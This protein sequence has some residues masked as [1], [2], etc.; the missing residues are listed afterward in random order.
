MVAGKGIYLA[1]ISSK[2]AQYCCSRFS[3]GGSSLL[4][5]CE[6]ELG[7]PMLELYSGN[8][9]AHAISACQGS[10]ATL[11]IGRLQHP[12]WKDASCVHPDLKGVEMVSSI[13]VF[14][15]MAK[16]MRLIA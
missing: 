15:N 8:A 4:L 1:D 12:K 10:I 5:L 16:L 3:D 9:N 2:S 6:V 13:F 14:R 11:G 7:R